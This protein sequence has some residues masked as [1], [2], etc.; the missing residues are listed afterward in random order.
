MLWSAEIT[1]SNPAFRA[2]RKRAPLRNPDHL[3]AR[4]VETSWPVSSAARWRGSDSSISS[5]NAANDLFRELQRRDRLFS[6]HR[7]E[8][9]EK[10]L[11]RVAGFEVIEQVVHG[12]ARPDENREASH[13]L[14]IAVN[15][16]FRC[17]HALDCTPPYNGSTVAPMMN[18]LKFWLCRKA[19]TEN[20]GKV[21]IRDSVRGYYVELLKRR[22]SH[23]SR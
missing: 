17:S 23:T 6:R 15:D 21:S 3:C 12:H 16:L 9:I 22:A 2:A 8:G 14:R 20:V 5:R 4:T 7:R 18:P 13:D 10:L 1:T 19:S 11:E